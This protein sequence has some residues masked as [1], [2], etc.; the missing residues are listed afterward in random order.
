M[1]MKKLD[2]LDT[3]QESM[4]KLDDTVVKLTQTT[5]AFKLTTE[6]FIQSA[7]RELSALTER[8][9]RADRQ[10]E[11]YGREMAAMN[12]KLACAEECNKVLQLQLNDLENK[13]RVCNLKIEGKK[14]EDNEDVV[15]YTSELTEFLT[16]GAIDKSA[17]ISACRLGKKTY[18]QP[19]PGQKNQPRPR[20]ILLTFKSIQERNRVYYARTKLRNDDSF[21]HIY[22][23]DDTTQLTRKFREDFRSV[24]ALVRGNDKEVRIHDDGIVIEGRKYRHTDVDQLPTEFTIEKAKTVR[25]GDGLYF[26]SERAFLSNFYPS[27]ITDKGHYYPTAEHWLQAKKCEMENELDK[28]D[29]VMRAHTPLDAKRVGDR[30]DET[31]EWRN[32]R[33]GLINQ[34]MDLKFDQNKDLSTKLIG[35]G[36]LKL[37]EATTNSYY[38]IGAALHSRELRNQQ[39]NG[40][41]KLGHALMDKRSKLI[42]AQTTN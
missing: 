37:H 14:E 38:G 4:S 40:L 12:H 8:V 35:T 13:S 23:N 27:P 31:Q 1:I 36:K 41:N 18:T 29:S 26:Q 25:I 2:K 42:T 3:L 39:F 15:K 5:E 30:I 16:E 7:S 20:P 17:I 19:Q 28:L 22:L 6:S 10:H 33:E 34:L 11:T 21:K 24:A 9:N 32:A